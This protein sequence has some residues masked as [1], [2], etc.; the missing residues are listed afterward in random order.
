MRKTLIVGALCVAASSLAAQDSSEYYEPSGKPCYGIS[1]GQSVRTV[2]IKSDLYVRGM[3]S[4]DS[5][6]AIAVCNVPGQ[7]SSG[8][9]ESDGNRTL[10]EISLLP[11]NRKTYTK[12]LIDAQ[13]GEVLSTKQI[14][15]VSGYAGCLRE[16]A[17][18]R[19]NKAP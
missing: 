8:E 7:V 11:T 3:I 9:M 19:E 5:A 2:A 13:T 1:H 15:G 10:Y 16:S 14:C 4:P 12:V 6:K 18:R 17:K